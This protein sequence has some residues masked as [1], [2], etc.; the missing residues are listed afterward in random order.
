M[1]AAQG[2][3]LLSRGSSL[4][5]RGG[6]GLVSGRES[7]IGTLRV[8]LRGRT[9]S[10]G[11]HSRSARS[12]RASSLRTGARSV[13]GSTREVG[14]RFRG[15]ETLPRASFLQRMFPFRSLC[16]GTHTTPFRFHLR[17]AHPVLSEVEPFRN[18]FRSPEECGETLPRGSALPFAFHR[19][20]RGRATRRVA[21]SRSGFPGGAGK[22]RDGAPS[23]G[24]RSVESRSGQHRFPS[25]APSR[26][27]SIE[28]EQEAFCR[29]AALG[30][31]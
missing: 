6:P 26:E 21:G 16:A 9:L 15:G 29:R 14:G 12:L 11:T 17:G 3:V 18:T 25:R 23:S 31:G 28:H 20:E 27:R 30:G 10:Q 8:S 7:M 13:R 4:L 2:R 19:F 22:E 1:A 24:A 5:S